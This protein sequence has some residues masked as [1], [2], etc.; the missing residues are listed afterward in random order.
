MSYKKEL[1][2]QIKVG[3]SLTIEKFETK[4][5][6]H[7]YLL[8]EEMGRQ[9]QEYIKSL[10]E[11]KAV[12]NSAIVISA[13]EGIV[14]SHDSNLLE[15]NGG[16]IKCTKHRAKHFLIRLGY[17]KRKAPTKAS[18]S[19]IDFTAQKEQFFYLIFRPLLRWKI[20]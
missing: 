4:K 7:P 17:V 20:F 11:A 16:H 9:L 15:S 8:G 5:R 10:R 3:G 2:N 12:I 1:A 19:S 14:K 6:G 13:A 18:I